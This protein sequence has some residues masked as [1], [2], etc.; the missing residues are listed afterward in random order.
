MNNNIQK[1]DFLNHQDKLISLVTGGAGFIGTNLC[2]KLLSMGHI[3]ICL[4][5]F[6]TGKYNNI[7]Q[8]LSNDNFILKNDDVIYKQSF[9]KIDYIWHL[10]CPASPPKYQVDGYKTLQTS[11]FGTINMLELAH[12]HNC[13]LLF[14]STSEVYG[15]PLIEEQDETYWGNVNPVGERSCY[16]EGKRCAETII[17]EFR[18]K[19]PTLKNKLKIVRLFN[20]YGP[21]MDIDDGRVITNFIKS[22][23]ENKPITIYG[24][25]NQNRSFC[26][27]D[28]LIDGLIKMMNSNQ[29]GPI[30]LGNPTEKFTM[31]ELKNIL[32][33]IMNKNH[34]VENLSLPS[35]DPKQRKPN[36]QLAR[37]KLNWEPQ[38]K[39]QEGI[40]LTVEYFTK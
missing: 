1:L 38:I 24:D 6:S 35:D 40:K 21:Y 29:V 28:D 22:S 34:Q 19:Y 25:G 14:T 26:F 11:L 31:N 20:T 23:L 2:K 3:V 4:D 37:E 17:Y 27:I 39:I 33:L 13:L 36:I 7:K 8:F 15:D 30:N 5:N 9:P 16:D 10:A 12:T 18:K 32:D